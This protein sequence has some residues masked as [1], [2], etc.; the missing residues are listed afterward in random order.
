MREGS[1]ATISYAGCSLRH[2][3]MVSDTLSQHAGVVAQQTCNPSFRTH[4]QTKG[5][6]L[7]PV[8]FRAQFVECVPVTGSTRDTLHPADRK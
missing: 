2:R 7:H 5:T 3:P 1:Y 4:V 8:Y 6:N